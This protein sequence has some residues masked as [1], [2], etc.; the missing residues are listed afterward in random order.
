MVWTIV[1]TL[2]IL[3]VSLPQATSQSSGVTCMASFSWASNSLKQ[4]PCLV[5]AYLLGTCSGGAHEVPPLPDNKHYVGPTTAT[6]DACQCNT[7]V[8][9]LMSACGECQNRTISG[10]GEWSANCPHV[11]INV[12]PGEIPAGTRVPGWAYLDVKVLKNIL[13]SVNLAH[14]LVGIQANDAFDDNLAKANANST[15]SAAPQPTSSSTSSSRHSATGSVRTSSTSSAAPSPISTSAPTATNASSSSA[16]SDNSHRIDQ[17]IGGTIG[18]VFALGILGFIWLYFFRKR[19]DSVGQQ[20]LESQTTSQ[21]QVDIPEMKG[22]PAPA[23][24]V[25]PDIVVDGNTK[26]H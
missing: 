4:S 25:S 20:Q 1:V 7:V 14:S 10:W 5:A 12:F 26:K 21:E 9:S 16:T 8:Y 19:R 6:A 17:I 15:E 18:G 11:D 13:E 24:V 22:P 3:L 2:T 23:T